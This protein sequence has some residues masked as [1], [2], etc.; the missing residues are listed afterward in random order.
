MI[1]Y[2]AV[3]TQFSALATRAQIGISVRRGAIDSAPRRYA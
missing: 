3:V 1:E 2:V